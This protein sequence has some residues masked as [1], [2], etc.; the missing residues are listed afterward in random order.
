MLPPASA[1]AM[2]ALPSPSKSATARNP[3]AV[4]A[5]YPTA[6]ANAPP[7]RFMST[8]TVP[9]TPFAT[10]RSG[11]PSPSNSPRRR[12]TARGRPGSHGRRERAVAQAEEIVTESV[13]PSA[14]ARSCLP[15]PSKSAAATATCCESSGGPGRPSDPVHTGATHAPAWHV[16]PPEHAR[17]APP[18]H[19]P[20]WQ[21]LPTRH[22][23]VLGQGVPLCG[24]WTGTPPWHTSSVHASW[25]STGSTPRRPL[26][27]R[28][29]S[30]RSSK[31]S[32]RSRAPSRRR[33]SRSSWSRIGRRPILRSPSRRRGARRPG[34]GKPCAS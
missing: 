29:P 23:S 2:S 9:P 20:A 21:V 3:G 1:T 10:T 11:L 7:P 15:S 4:T 24:T 8:L 12:S 5:A 28:R 18:P 31:R 27:R 13:S 16:D 32:S 34:Q 17:G 14:T 19:T 26:P 25:S 30:R 33:R 6:G 22:G